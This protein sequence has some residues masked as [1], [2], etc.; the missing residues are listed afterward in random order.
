[1]QSLCF[2]LSSLSF[3]RDEW[4]E[5]VKTLTHWLAHLEV[6]RS[7]E[8]LEFCRGLNQQGHHLLRYT[9]LFI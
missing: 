1:M 3:S 7:L 8:A 2:F 6:V 9:C 5:A 4:T